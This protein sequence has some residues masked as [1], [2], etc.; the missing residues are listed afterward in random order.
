MRTAAAYDAGAPSFDRHRALPEGVAPAIRAAL[1]DSIGAK[2]PPRLL[3]IGA[4]TGR[5]GW[6]FAAAGDNYVGVDL[7]VGM[8]R[9]FVLRP[10]ESKD[11]APCLVQADGDRLPFRNATFDAVLLM[12]V[13][14]A[15][16]DWRRLVS[17]AAR[18]LHL[19][20]HLIVGRTIAPH[21][22]VDAQLKQRLAEILR[23]MC[24]EPYRKQSSDDALH[25]LIHQY[26]ENQ[27]V[28]AATWTAERTPGRFLQRHRHS[29]QF[30]ALPASVKDTAMLHLRDWAIARFGSLNTRFAEMF[31]F[32]LTICHL[33]EESRIE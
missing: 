12:H 28:T 14:N 9:Q 33:S 2:T 26:S 13:L 20:G 32:E 25:W 7:S 27:T 21:N 24:V 18:V 29:G 22:G 23:T 6:P 17:E 3:D 11:K 19:N 10:T 31:H 4:G 5:F 8:L 16:R 1:L 30:S 15:V